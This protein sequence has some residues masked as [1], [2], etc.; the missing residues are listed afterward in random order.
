MT[1]HE[2]GHDINCAAVLGCD[3]CDCNPKFICLQVEIGPRDSIHESGLMPLCH[4]WFPEREGLKTEVSEQWRIQTAYYT[5]RGVKQS[6]TQTL[7]TCPH[8]HAAKALL[9]PL[10]APDEFVL[11]SF[12]SPLLDAL[13]FPR[14]RRG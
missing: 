4:A 8:C 7:V 1:L 10:M 3:A 12:K 5:K 2:S 9:E 13:L 11:T 14:W 6:G